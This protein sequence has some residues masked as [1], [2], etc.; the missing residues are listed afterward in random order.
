MNNDR[1]IKAT[2]VFKPNEII[3]LEYQNSCVY[4]EAIQVIPQRR[5]CW[6]R[7][8]FMITYSAEINANDRQERITDLRSC[9]DLLWPICLFRSAL[10]VEVLP[11]LTA[12][13]DRE[14]AAI[15]RFQSSSRFNQFI[16]QVW[17]DNQDK[18]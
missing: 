2:P 4:G 1:L 18:F 10:D 12:D 16:K 15:D 9:S 8:L 5:L 14:K 3:C 6:F 17:Q 13:R 11:F 7:P